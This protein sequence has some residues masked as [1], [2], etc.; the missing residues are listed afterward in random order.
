MYLN[1]IIDTDAMALKYIHII[2]YVG[3]WLHY[4]ILYRYQDTNVHNINTILAVFA[5]CLRTKVSL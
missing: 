2:T 3:E 1:I 4:N 5:R